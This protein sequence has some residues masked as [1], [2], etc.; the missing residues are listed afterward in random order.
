MKK[1]K[2]IILIFLIISIT[3]FSKQNLA[4]LDFEVISNNSK[5]ENLGKNIVYHIENSQRLRK[6]YNLVERNELEDLLNEQKL[7]LMGITDYEVTLGKMAGA[8]LIL[9]GRITDALG[10]YIISAKLVDVDTSLIL[11]SKQ[12]T[13]P[14]KNNFKSIGEKITKSLI[15]ENDYFEKGIKYGE[16]EISE[17]P[18]RMG[19]TFGL[20]TP[21]LYDYKNIEKIVGENILTVAYDIFKSVESMEVIFED[22]ETFAEK[23]FRIGIFGD[24]KI[25]DFL[26]LSSEG[27][28]CLERI[29]IYGDLLVKGKGEENLALEEIM[30]YQ[31]E[32][33]IKKYEI[34]LNLKMYLPLLGDVK[35]GIIAGV[36]GAFVNEVRKE[37]DSFFK[38]NEYE[39][40]MNSKFLQTEEKM[41]ETNDFISGFQFGLDISFFDKY[42]G[43]FKYK[44]SN[45][46]FDNDYYNFDF[47][48]EQFSLNLYYKF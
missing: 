35:F 20:G 7:S 12:Y 26:Y 33:E 19:I 45:S 10:G 41:T 3:V 8:D 16:E 28:F 44:Y 36:H 47:G 23:G 43:I 13:A 34:P 31:S 32:I 38:S 9:Y 29:A 2:I 21:W 11:F 6:I 22:T 5:N 18:F 48:I 27:S 42:D 17:N 30:S 14:G 39:I 15:L 40:V 46:V 4:V 1:Q 37:Q 25:T 24:Y